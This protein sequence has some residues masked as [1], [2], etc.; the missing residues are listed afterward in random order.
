L[1][2]KGGIDAISRSLAMEYVK[3]GIRVNTLYA[4]AESMPST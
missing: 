4:S 1:I 2:T 3:E